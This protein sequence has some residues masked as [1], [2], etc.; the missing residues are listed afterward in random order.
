MP[1][2]KAKYTEEDPIKVDLKEVCDYFYEEDLA[3]RQIQ[4][5]FWK[6][7]KYYWNNFSQIFWSERD[8]S[9]II[10]GRDNSDTSGSN[11]Q[12]YYDRPVNV[13]K[14]FLETIVAAL[15][16]NIPAV[17]CM[18][19]DADNP[20]DI[21]TAKAGNKISELLYK[22]NNAVFLWLH[23]LYIYCTEGL[24]A[25][26]TYEDEDEKYGTYEKKNY[27]DEQVTG[28]FCPSCKQQLD[29]G[30]I[31]QAKM[32]EERMAVKFD[33][34]E[35]DA[36]LAEYEDD[37]PLR[38][39]GEELLEPVVCPECA[40][41]IDGNL[42]QSTLTI[43]KFVG[44]TNNPKSRLCMEVYGGL[45]VKVANYAKKQADTP[46]LA[47]MYDT[48]YA[49]VLEVYDELWDKIDKGGWA[50]NQ[51]NDPIEQ[52]ARLNIQYRGEVPRDNVTVKNF[53]LRPAAFN[54]LTQEKAKKLKEKYPNGCKVVVVQDIIAH[55]C[56]ESLDD[57]WTL[58]Q[59]PTSDYLNHEPLGEVVVNIQDIV[60][61]LISLTL[62]LIEHGIP[63]N[64]V[65]PSVV[66]VP[67]I[68]QREVTPGAY[69]PTKQAIGNKKISE[70]FHS[71]QAASVP[72]ELFAFYKIINELG[73]FVS[74]ALPSIFGGALPNSGETLGEYQESQRMALQRLQTPWKMLT[75]WWKLV[76][77]KAIPQYM[78]MIVED[79]KFV[80]KDQQGN[81]INV[82]IRKAE[83]VG[84]LGDVELDNS[85]QLPV[86]EEQQKDIIMQLMQLNNVEV[87]E[88]L[89]SPENLPYVRKICRIP[90]FRLP[91]EDDRQKQYEEIQELINSVPIPL[92]GMPMEEG[93]EIEEGMP[94]Q[95]N[96]NE[97]ETSAGASSFTSSIPI[98]IILDNHKV[99]AEICR[100][101]LVGDAG[102]LAKVENPDGYANI[103][104]H[105]QEH[106]Q[107]YNEQ[108]KMMQ[109][110]QAAMS[111]GDE[112]TGQES[113][114]KTK[115][116]SGSKTPKP[117][118]G[119]KNG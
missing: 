36:E 38:L 72:P 62:Q 47:W 96:E 8:G 66:D 102:R 81:F 20:N 34:N 82:L 24:I 17:S 56:A 13:F 110:S 22:R 98:D 39:S 27:E 64:W 5:R 52:Y 105:F 115:N 87:F 90:Q 10:P 18:P 15:S 91:G 79:E 42:A 25:C 30:M 65:D 1:P 58:T 75:I 53:W 4:V 106:T 114:D 9:Y 26:Y 12:S 107:A 41:A 99:E 68:G 89:A 23:A 21:S 118:K 6:R 67:A 103:L 80:K 97:V 63:E 108:V 84:K 100:N 73:Q 112:T 57:H 86:T 59:N 37:K 71:T 3:V 16:V 88:A 117:G 116:P 32:I 74:G 29:E 31:E 83:L 61:D 93:M 85:D 60:N 11:D 40:V 77:G 70:A 113:K 51:G 44:I 48:H 94:P 19:D 33:S 2:S 101:W 14:A 69:S 7:L 43:P 46:Y 95:G 92:G 54:I 78:K 45:Y 28:F 35:E 55:H 76:M 49:N 50:S 119:V 104:L 109:M 111:G